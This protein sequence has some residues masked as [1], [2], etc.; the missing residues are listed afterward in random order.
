MLAGVSFIFPALIMLERE[1]G[2]L[3]HKLLIGTLL[4]MGAGLLI[5]GGVIPLATALAQALGWLGPGQDEAPDGGGG[6][7][8]ARPLLV[9]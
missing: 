2:G 9:L 5:N 3:G 1:K 6:V 4:G 8:L 7:Q